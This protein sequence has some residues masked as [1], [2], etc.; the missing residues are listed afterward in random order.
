MLGVVERLLA[1]AIAGEVEL[2]LAVV[3]EREREHPRAAAQDA[4]EPPALVAL[5]QD[6]GVGQSR[7]FMA[8]LFEFVS[9]LLE[10]VNLAV[11]DEPD[12]P[13]D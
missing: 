12:V 2:L 10:I 3:V 6:L 7:E 4:V 1:G 9:D 11:E 8:Q 5:D 13:V